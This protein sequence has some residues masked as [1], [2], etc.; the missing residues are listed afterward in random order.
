MVTGIRLESFQAYFI[1]YAD[2]SF[3]QNSEIKKRRSMGF[4]GWTTVNKTSPGCED[5]LKRYIRSKRTRFCSLHAVTAAEPRSR[6][7]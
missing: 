6:P 4:R 3:F 2:Q 5:C 7:H 1:S